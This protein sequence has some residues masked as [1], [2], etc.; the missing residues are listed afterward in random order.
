LY[1]SKLSANNCG[2]DYLLWCRSAASRASRT[3]AV[4]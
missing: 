1:Q 3:A 4:S 2:G